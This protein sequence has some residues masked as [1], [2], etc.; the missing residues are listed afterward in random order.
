M[1]LDDLALALTP[2]LGVKGIRHLLA[3]FGSAEAVFAASEAD[4]R[5]AGQLR[6]PALRS[7]L[8]RA[9]F[10]AAE[11]EAAHA[12]RHGLKIVAQTDIEYPP[13]MREMNDNPHILYIEGAAEA[14]HGPCLS[15]VGTRE[16]SPYGERVCDRLIRDL[17]ARIPD[18]VVVSGLAFG[19]DS[20]CHRAALAYGLRTVAVVASALPD[21]TPAQHAG[22]AR[23]IVAAGGAVVSELPS[24]TRQN[25][26]YYVARNRIIA[27]L[28]EGT[29]V[30]ESPASG[31]ALVTANCADSYNRVVMAV[32]GR[33]GDRT[34][35]GTNALIRNR[36]A[37][38][39]LSAEDIIRELMWDLRPETAPERPQPQAEPLPLTDDEA[40]LLACFRSDDPM[41]AA[42]LAAASGFDAGALSALLVGLELAGA[43]R[44]LPGNR[45]ETWN[46]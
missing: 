16:A 17:A 12:A 22:L 34:A 32:P 15:L 11:H 31:G 9:G 44:Q 5:R 25:G 18:L 38:M 4:L 24:S 7:L 10:R 20:I 13:L 6:E 8:G 19:I 45:Y 36:K 40:R 41:T 26:S 28:S 39:I 33:I 29:V 23:D 2:S 14:L 37:Q 21:I 3:C 27:G 46:R 35:W 43:V 30:V 1:T 42:E